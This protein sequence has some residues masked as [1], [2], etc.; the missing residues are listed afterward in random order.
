LFKKFLTVF[1]QPTGRQFTSPLYAEKQRLTQQKGSQYRS[2]LNVQ[3]SQPGIDQNHQHPLQHDDLPVPEAPTVQYPAAVLCYSRAGGH[4]V[5]HYSHH[6]I[7]LKSVIIYGVF[8]AAAETRETQVNAG[9]SIKVAAVPVTETNDDD[10]N[11]F[12]HNFPLLSINNRHTRTGSPP[13]KMATSQQAPWYCKYA[14]QPA[15]IRHGVSPIGVQQRH[16][17][18]QHIVLLLQS[19]AVKPGEHTH[20][21][22]FPWDKDHEPH[23]HDRRPVSIATDFSDKDNTYRKIIKR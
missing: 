23:R 4:Q 11:W 9:Y 6:S 21:H 17:D 1:V 20:Q 2:Y 8:C 14:S 13:V 18:D 3:L 10:H 19:P 5:C 22:G 12:K 7:L 16:D 15:G